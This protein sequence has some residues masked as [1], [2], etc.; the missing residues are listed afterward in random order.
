MLLYTD[1]V[2][3]RMAG[4]EIYGWDRLKQVLAAGAAPRQLVRDVLADVE[5][6]GG[7][8]ED[9]MTLLAVRFGPAG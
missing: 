2:V 9:D 7:E 1:G 6:F 3:E 5:R 4:D 8:Q